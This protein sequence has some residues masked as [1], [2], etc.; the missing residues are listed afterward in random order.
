MGYQLSKLRTIRIVKSIYKLLSKR[1]KI[2]IFL[3]V[4]LNFFSS[5]AESISVISV[6]PLISFLSRSDA[7][8]NLF[9]I[10]N[11]I[12]KE[13]SLALIISTFIFFILITQI[14]KILNLYSNQRVASLIGL[15]FSKTAY[16]NIINRN[17]IYFIESSSSSVINSLSSN[18]ESFVL[19]LRFILNGITFL[20]I[21][22]FLIITSFTVNY[23]L[24]LILFFLLSTSYILIGQLISRKVLINSKT[25]VNLTNSIIKIIQESFGQIKDIILNNSHNIYIDNYEKIEK[26]RKLKQAENVFFAYFPKYIIETIGILTL[27]FFALISFEDNQSN[28]TISTIGAFALTIQRLLPSAQIIYS[29]WIGIRANYSAMKNIIDINNNNNNKSEFHFKDKIKLLKFEKNITLKDISFSYGENNKNNLLKNINL[30]IKQGDFIGITGKTGEGKSTLIDIITGIIIPNKGNLF[31]DDIGILNTLEKEKLLRSW[32]KNISYVPQEIF[33]S[34]GDIKENISLGCDKKEI[35]FNRIKECAEV[36]QIDNF[37]KKLPKG[38]KTKAGEN[39]VKLSGG[40]R[41]RIGIARAIYKN[42]KLLILDEA[43]SGIDLGTEEKLFKSLMQYKKMITII[44]ISHR[45]KS[46]QFCNKRF[47]LEEHFLKKLI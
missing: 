22:F 43:T 41:Q 25:I 1:R 15:D 9:F 13:S 46:L 8:Y 4:I 47:I 24:T 33:I 5:I 36:T 20:L 17:Y 23:K 27:S 18:I 34:E 45:K 21:S 42:K 12:N 3:L 32:R 6:I 10:D 37:I 19:G 30:E 35:D 2:Q 31:I 38:Y 28:Q 40:Q 11:F 29:S 7:K 14:L 39:G 44:M 16:K 26:E